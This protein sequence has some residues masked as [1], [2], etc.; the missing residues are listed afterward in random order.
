M[1]DLIFL[2]IFFFFIEAISLSPND[3]LL[4]KLRADCRGKLEMKDLAINDY[5]TFLDLKERDHLR[6]V[7]KFD[8]VRNWNHDYSYWPFHQVLP[9]LLYKIYS[10]AS[11]QFFFLK[12]ENKN[13]MCLFFIE[14]KKNLLEKFFVKICI[15]NFSFALEKKLKYRRQK[16]LQNKAITNQTTK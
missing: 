1:L 3:A 11:K 5:K 8:R 7:A 16:S 15:Y 13:Q 2:F 4:F 14:I 9:I 10:F 12:N 6:K